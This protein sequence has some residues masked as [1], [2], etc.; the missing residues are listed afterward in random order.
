MT[1]IP[2]AERYQRALRGMEL[3]HALSDTYRRLLLTHYRAAGHTMT[4]CQLADAVGFKS[5]EAVNLHYGTFGAKLAARMRWPVP[6]GWYQ[7]S[8][9]ATFEDGAADQ[10]HTRW[11]LRPEVVAAVEQLRWAGPRPAAA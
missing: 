6:D 5:Y 3:T 11:V 4:A 7:A 9:F 8:T 2:S 1:E 10:P